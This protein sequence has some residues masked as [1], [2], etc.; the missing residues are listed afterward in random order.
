MT[1][2]RLAHYGLFNAPAALHSLKLLGLDARS[3]ERLLVAVGRSA[4]PDQGLI[5]LERFVHSNPTPRSFR[6]RLLAEPRALE[7]ASVLC[8]GSAF[9]A[10]ALIREPAW[11]D[12]ILGRLGRARTRGE[13]ARD[14]VK[15][16]DADALRVA[17]RRELLLIG[18]RDLLRLATV[19]ETLRALSVLADVLIERAC[20]LSAVGR[21][22]AVVA[23]G[24]LGGGELNFSSDVDLLY[25]AGPP[26]ARGDGARRLAWAVTAALGEVT[27][28]GHVYRVDLRL[29]PEGRTGEIAPTIA[30]AGNY[31]RD[32]AS[33][34]ERLAL[35]KA[36]PVAGDR[37]LGLRF[38][39]KVRV[40]VFGRPFGPTALH[41]LR[42]AK[43]L[44]DRRLQARG[45]ADRN[46]KLGFGGI[47]EIE[48]VA[49]SL[50]LRFAGRRKALREKGTLRTLYALRE[51][52]LLPA[53]QADALARAYLFLR[54]V[55]NKLQIAT[56]TQSHTLPSGTPAMRSLA[57]RLGYGD[58]AGMKAEAAFLRDCQSATKEVH[59]IFRQVFELRDPS[60]DIG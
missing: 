38:L 10:E 60:S 2:E 8:G 52:S 1:P 49:H 43:G 48:F 34:W 58:T 3:S 23:L 15:V 46:V 9:L 26:L 4:D 28:E 24:K 32:R 18:A 51:A 53:G 50:Q 39:E 37:A 55:E 33:S 22:F 20:E 31:Y 54:D 11:F 59:R 21:G 45:E 25:L 41:E 42:V 35:V 27:S 6:K 47:R 30:S 29:R 14:V 7:L 17:K 44:M 57:R 12:W 56:G 13:I 36:R 19:E 5:L 16:G 40:F